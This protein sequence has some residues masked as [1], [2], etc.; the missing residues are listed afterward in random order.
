MGPSPLSDICRIGIVVTT[1]QCS[2]DADKSGNNIQFSVAR[3]LG[4]VYS[5][6]WGAS[7]KEVMAKDM[8]KMYVTKN[9]N[10]CL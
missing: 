5:N 3:R 4:S 7:I 10:Y 6:L 8:T 1:L 2:F 9:L